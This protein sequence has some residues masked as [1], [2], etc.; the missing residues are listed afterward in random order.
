VNNTTVF[1]VFYHRRVANHVFVDFDIPGTFTVASEPIT[2]AMGNVVGG[3]GNVTLGAHFGRHK[4]IVVW[5]A[6]GALALPFSSISS[7]TLRL[8]NTN[9]GA[10]MAGWN[11]YFWCVGELPFVG[12][13]G[14]EL[15]P[16]SA[17]A[18]RLD[19]DPMTYI[20]IMSGATGEV[21]SQERFEI[22]GRAAMGLGAGAGVM[23]T[24]RFNSV[25][26]TLAPPTTTLAATAT[27][28]ALAALEAWLGYDDG[29]NFFMRAGGLLALNSP[30][31]PGFQ[32]GGALTGQILLG[33]HLSPISGSDDD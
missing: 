1:D 30:L 23:A 17:L 18:L 16:V 9:G 14:V 25:S 33:V 15:R 28:P 26:S 4:G 22:E 27:A 32:R 11:D 19:F 29:H 10:A 13:F 12:R 8:A 3:V 24:T 6:G 7:P 20:P 2:P 21:L 31:G 5:H